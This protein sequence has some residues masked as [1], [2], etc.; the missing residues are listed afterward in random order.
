MTTAWAQTAPVAPVAKDDSS[1]VVELSPFVVSEQ[2]NQ[3]YRAAQTMLG[4]RSA[5]D[6]VDIPSSISIINLEMMNDFNAE[7]VHEVFRYGVSGA[8]QNQTFNEDMNVRGFRSI[9]ST[10]RDG[11]PRAGGSNKFPPL[12]DVERVEVLKG[13]GAMLTGTNTPIGGTINYISRA[14]TDK[15]KGEAQVTISD[16]GGFRYQ[17]NVS[18]PAV[19]SG[20]FRMNYRVTVGGL[21]EDEPTSTPTE[22][23]KQQFFGAGLAFYFGSRTSIVAHA[24]HFIDDTYRYP[25]DFLDIT[26]PVDPVTGLQEARLN[27]YSVRG[28]APHQ[29]KHG[30]WPL[31]TQ[32]ASVTLLSRLLDD[33]NL[34]MVYGYYWADDNATR[35]RGITV[36]ANNF[37]LNRQYG[38][39]LLDTESH[40]LQMDLMHTF[41]REHFKLNTSIGADGT[42]G[43]FIIRQL[44]GNISALD[45]RTP[46]SVYAADD[47]FFAQFTSDDSFFVTRPAGFTGTPTKTKTSSRAASY[48][49][50]ENASFWKD[51]IILAGG[52]RWYKPQQT[53]QNDVANTLTDSNLDNFQVHNYG[54]VF[55][56][57]PQVSLYYLNSENVFPPDAAVFTDRFTSGDRLGEPFRQQEGQLE[58]YGVKFQHNFT[59]DFQVYGSV[60]I[61]DMAQ[62]NL[63]TTGV[64]E[65]GQ[66]GQVQS[67]R[68]ESEGWETDIG[69]QAKAGPGRFDVILTYFDGTSN[70]SSAVGTKVGLAKEANNF[71]PTNYSALVKYSWAE[72]ALKGLMLGLGTYKE[73]PLRNATFSISRPQRYDGFARYV[74]GNSW[75]AQVNLENLT[76]ERYIVQVYG[77]GLVQAS[78]PFRT[79][80]TVRYR[81]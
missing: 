1:E 21:D 34:R 57:L 26:A 47:A 69:I 65:S 16:T 9:N 3:G 67:G 49:I 18:G 77:T 36:A 35:P 4:S 79:R 52:L 15:F 10:L 62:T 43:R 19:K 23:Q 25:Q 12:Y 64:L 29:K 28:F 80:F 42:S 78:D 6:L 70:V 48:Y 11:V 60:A 76:D 31:T 33:L 55:K 53:I 50:F 22:F 37:T 51:R 59:K 39:F 75:E 68:D 58:E 54:V 13:P 73:D 44:N 40:N 56:V 38:R 24:Y 41:T 27:Q 74:W 32:G 2:S 72:G 45:T 66:L 63:R 46:S 14:P 81:W 17:A 30:E 7:T 20:D 71:V 61:F 8:T 5:K